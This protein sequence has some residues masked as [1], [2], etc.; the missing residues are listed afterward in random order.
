MHVAEPRP[1]RHLHASFVF[2]REAV[3][4]F[5]LRFASHA[6]Q[7]LPQ[8][9]LLPLPLR[10]LGGPPRLGAAATAASALL[11]LRPPEALRKCVHWHKAAVHGP[12]AAHPVAQPRRLRG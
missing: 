5:I 12:R 7:P 10:L 8:Q 2:V 9:S 3:G 11:P 6:V 4:S 1:S